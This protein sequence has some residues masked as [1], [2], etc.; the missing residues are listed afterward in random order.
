M[1]RPADKTEQKN[2]ASLPLTPMDLFEFNRSMQ[3][4]SGENYNRCLQCRTCSA[5][6]P[7]S[8]AMD[9]K[10]NQILRMIQFG[11]TG[12]LLSCST[13]WLCVG[14]HT[15]TSYCPMNIDIPSVM[16]ALRAR[17]LK[18]GV[19]PAEPN[20]LNFHHQVLDSIRRHGRTHKLGIMMRYKFTSGDLLSDMDVGLKMLTRGK[21]ELMPK[22]IKDAAKVESM[23]NG[24]EHVY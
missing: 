15:C 10:P 2:R 1:V 19:K 8:R 21:L 16:D 6:C 24:K 13:I 7:F 12:K 4:A 23:F 5:A 18:D 11:M 14:C 22:S 20:I 3:K 9:V 17:A